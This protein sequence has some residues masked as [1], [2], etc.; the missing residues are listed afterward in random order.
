M[1][2]GAIDVPLLLFDREKTRLR[3]QN[4]EVEL[5]RDF[6]NIQGLD[7]KNATD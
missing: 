7:A 5:R 2:G 1:V 3:L 4:F 6:A